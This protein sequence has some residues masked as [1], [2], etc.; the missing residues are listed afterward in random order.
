MKTPL[1]LTDTPV[2]S[3]N[4][5]LVLNLAGCVR[6]SGAAVVSQRELCVR[7]GRAAVANWSRQ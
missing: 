3:K 6:S 5:N 1:I 2:E 7:V 4:W